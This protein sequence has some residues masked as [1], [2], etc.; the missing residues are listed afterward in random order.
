MKDDAPSRLDSA[1]A[2]VSTEC[3]EGWSVA[4]LKVS[5]QNTSAIH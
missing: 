2:S 5:F 3:R 4:S 1:V